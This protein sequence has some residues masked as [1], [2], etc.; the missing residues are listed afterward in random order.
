LFY[1]HIY[2][3]DVRETTNNDIKLSIEM[4]TKLKEWAHDFYKDYQDNE[5]KAIL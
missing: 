3:K 1:E 5:T 2:K 4:Q